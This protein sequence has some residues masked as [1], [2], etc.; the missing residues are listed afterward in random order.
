MITIHMRIMASH[1]ININIT[2]VTKVD[3]VAVRRTADTHIETDRLDCC[4]TK[5][6]T[7]GLFVFIIWRCWRRCAHL[8]DFGNEKTGL[9]WR[10]Q[11][12]D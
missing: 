12:F 2:L 4:G 10:G 5:L 9:W 8:D 11:C 1:I 7:L 3:L 6:L